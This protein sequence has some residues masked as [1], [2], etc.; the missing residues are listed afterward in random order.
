MGV[1]ILIDKELFQWEKDRFVSIVTDGKEVNC[2]QFFNAKSSTGPEVILE[3]NLAK[4]P[5]YLLKESLPI[6]ALACLKS[7][8]SLSV[9]ARKTFKVLKRVKPESYEEDDS[10]IKHIIYDG[11]ME[12]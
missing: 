8:N 1:K 5:N 4:I 3:G 9:I 11:G 7:E 2:V 12:L 6:T 10:T